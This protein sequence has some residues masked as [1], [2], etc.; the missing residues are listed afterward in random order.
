MLEAIQLCRHSRHVCGGWMQRIVVLVGKSITDFE[1]LQTTQDLVLEGTPGRDHVSIGDDFVRV[2]GEDARG[3]FIGETAIG[4]I[5]GSGEPSK[6]GGLVPGLASSEFSDRGD[7]AV[8]EG[9]FSKYSRFG[10]LGCR[11]TNSGVLHVWPV[12]GSFVIFLD[13][14]ADVASS[15][16]TSS[17]KIEGER[18]GE[19]EALLWRNSDSI[20]RNSPGIGR[21]TLGEPRR[22][23]FFLPELNPREDAKRELLYRTRVIGRVVGVSDEPEE[24]AADSNFP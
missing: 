14:V 2:L 6:S 19:E 7:A 21:S 3:L 11:D 18:A 9:A 4:E 1:S 5:A 23:S 10:R 22:G 8:S 24:A 20:S 15:L 16:R 17:E 12:K 13:N